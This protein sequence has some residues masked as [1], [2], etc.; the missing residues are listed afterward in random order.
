MASSDYSPYDH[1][2]SASTHMYAPANAYAYSYGYGHDPGNN[3]RPSSAQSYGHVSAQTYGQGLPQPPPAPLPKQSYFLPGYGL[4]R[5]V[6][7]RRIPFFVGHNYTIRPFTY[8]HREGYLLT[9][10]G[11]P[12]TKVRNSWAHAGDMTHTL[13]EPD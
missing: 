13:K 12:L 2:G 1:S 4:S 5:H 6:I 8:N 10:D 3:T 11:A 7:M 9:H